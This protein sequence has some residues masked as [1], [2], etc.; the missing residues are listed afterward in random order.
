M[1]AYSNA[2]AAANQAREGGPAA[3][4]PL[5]I[6]A[7]ETGDRFPKRCVEVSAII[8]ILERRPHR[9][10]LLLE[11]GVLDYPS[12]EQAP[13]AHAEITGTGP[14]SLLWL[15]QWI[16]AR[17]GGRHRLD[18][19]L[20]SRNPQVVE[21]FQRSGLPRRPPNHTGRW[22]AVAYQGRNLV[23]VDYPCG[24]FP[25]GQRFAGDCGFKALDGAARDGYA[26]R[27]SY[28][29]RTLKALLRGESLSGGGARLKIADVRP[30]PP[31][32]G[33]ASTWI[34]R[35]FWSRVEV[36]LLRETLRREY[37]G[38]EDSKPVQELL[39]AIELMQRKAQTI[40]D[41]ELFHN[42]VK[43]RW[44]RASALFL[45]GDGGVG[46]SFIGKLLAPLI[47]GVN[48][49]PI[50][51]CQQGGGGHAQDVGYFRNQFFG[52][53]A[54]FEGGRELTTIG[55]HLDETQGYTVLI[56]DEVNTIAPQ[57]KDSMVVLFG[58]LEDRQYLPGNASL[59]GHKPINLWNTI[60]VLSANLSSF[61]PPEVPSESRGAI[62]R[63]VSAHHIRTLDREG[64]SQ[65][66]QWYLPA[67]LEKRLGGVV[68]CT[69]GDL[70][71][72]I[73]GLA[74]EAESP[75]ALIKDHLDPIVE[76]A[77]CALEQQG[78]TSL[79]SPLFLNVTGALRHA[80]AASAGR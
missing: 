26:Q 59:V 50:V 8:Q 78:I 13:R 62:E 43:A 54:G 73:A 35:E 39:A 72:D 4:F 77:Q 27:G 57:F 14:A 46:K 17:S 60:F 53:A 18:V 37:F 58:I 34:D 16:D 41:P 61:P 69:C 23:A 19:V 47:Y 3:A 31:P 42:T 45:W 55:H 51:M 36:H 64:I 32:R 25:W 48:E 24:G 38:A 70:R 20:Y 75:D 74:I 30:T 22:P 44:Q 80:L 12:P 71:D 63:R 29:N 66:G 21:A 52:P 40:A 68:V 49:P 10:L 33:A 1:S 65:F 76:T 7:T 28:P 2:G 6:S 67:T 56:L 5:Q 79:T 9:T 15:P 11:L